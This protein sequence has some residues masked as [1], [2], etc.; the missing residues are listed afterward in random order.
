MLII[1]SIKYGGQANS[2]V[3]SPSSL[4]E[5]VF[6]DYFW[7]FLIELIPCGLEQPATCSE[8]FQL[9]IA[10]FK[11]MKESRSDVLDL[12][13]TAQFLSRL[14]LDYKPKEVGILAPTLR[15]SLQRS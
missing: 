4:P 6:R 1:V 7:T 12:P 13:K 9:A 11:S 8:L 10:L 2:L 3:S 14:L 15:S 5:P